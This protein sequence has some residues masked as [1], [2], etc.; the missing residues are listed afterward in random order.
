MPLEQKQQRGRSPQSKLIETL[1]GILGIEYLQ[2]L[3]LG[4]QPIV[5]DPAVA[6]AWGQASFAHYTGVSRTLDA[7]EE[8]T[9]QGVVELLRQISQPFI[10]R[11]VV[12]TIRKKGGLIADVDLSGREVSPTSRDYQGA[13]FGWMDDDV[14]K[15]YQAAI[16]SLSCEL[17]QRLQVA[18]RRYTGR[19]HSAEC[20]QAAVQ[21]LEQIL[22]VRPQRRLALVEKRC[23]AVRTDGQALQARLER[24]EAEEQGFWSLL[25]QEKAARRSLVRSPTWKKRTG[26]KVGRRNPILLWPKPVWYWRR[27]RNGNRTS[28]GSCTRRKACTS[29]WNAN[30]RPCRISKPNWSNGWTNC[31]PTT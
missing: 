18:L 29:T 5:K 25:S 31:K 26:P 6:G 10:D 19:T 24:I 16:T 22:N 11:A 12:E 1:V 20:L 15:G 14:R 4:A 30:C 13:T 27:P 2:D 21:E 9:L 7:A 23:E 3:N 8:K 28:G 17:W